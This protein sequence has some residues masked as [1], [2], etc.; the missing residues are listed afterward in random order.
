MSDSSDHLR[1]LSEHYLSIFM[2]DTA[3]F[4]SERL[5]YEYPTEESLHLLAQCYFRQGKTNQT[6]LILQGCKL[7]ENRYLCAHCCFLLDKLPEAEKFLLPFSNAKPEDLK[8][9]KV[10]LVPGGAAGL[11]LLGSICRRANRRESAIDYF[12][13]SL[14]MEPTLWDSI[15]Q[16]CEMDAPLDLAS[17]FGIDE[18]LALN[19]LC[20]EKIP[21]FHESDPDHNEA[22]TGYILKSI[23]MNRFNG[24]GGADH[25]SQKRSDARQKIKPNTKGKKNRLAALYYLY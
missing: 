14:Q 21:F 23:D 3:K 5:Y 16:L 24:S 17:L 11:N 13:L 19:V 4:Y 22:D 8:P 12:K 2:Y 20:G 6:Y 10:H 1:R 18:K 15:E 9:E 25:F 7:P